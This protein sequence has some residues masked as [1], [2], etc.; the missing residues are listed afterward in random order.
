MTIPLGRER[1]TDNVRLSWWTVAGLF[2]IT[3]ATLMDEILLTRIFSVTTWYH[4]AFGAISLAMFGMT[5]G[6]L[7]V[8]Q[9]PQVFAATTAKRA[10][11]ESSLW[12]AI[13]A[14]GSVIAHL[15]VPFA[16]QPAIAFLWI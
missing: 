3:L 11:A 6:A 12:F 5:V 7:R 15:L 10:M 13:S 1:M 14:I 16:S 9:H 8:Y 4:F 2:L